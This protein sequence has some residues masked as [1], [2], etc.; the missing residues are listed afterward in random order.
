MITF[1]NI[2]HNLERIQD[3]YAKNPVTF[4]AQFIGL[5]V[6]ITSLSVPGAIVLTLLSGAIF[7]V[8]PGTLIVSLSATLGATIAFLYSRYIF[9]DLFREKFKDRITRFDTRFEEEGNAY[10]FSLRM[11]PVSPYVVINILMGLT[12]IK[13]WNYIWIT[14][15]GMLPGTLVYV[16]AGRKMSE[17]HSS[18]EILTLPILI[19]LTSIAFLPFFFKKLLQIIQGRN[20]NYG[21]H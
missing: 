16:Y 17:L 5:Y 3:Y 7:G 10:F 8:I 14:F 11:V 2:Q 20:E 9:R 6:L 21:H 19:L 13:L 4:T 1:E 15:L 18:S 12:P